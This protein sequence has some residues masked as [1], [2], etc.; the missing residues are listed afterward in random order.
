M[1]KEEQE[2]SLLE[3]PV[4]KRIADNHG[5]TTAQLCIAWAL[6]RGTT[7][8]VKSSSPERQKQ[9]YAAAGGQPIM[10]SDVEMS[11]IERLERGHRFFRPEEWWGDMAMAVFD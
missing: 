6:Q 7:V 11:Q 8:V 10:L 2:P 1:G 9:N 4:L 5:I 3:D